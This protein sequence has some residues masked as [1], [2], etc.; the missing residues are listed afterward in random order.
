[1][2]YTGGLAVFQGPYQVWEDG[3][4][5]S[6]HAGTQLDAHVL[7]QSHLALGLSV[8]HHPWDQ[9]GRGP[10]S[11]A[12]PEAPEHCLEDRGP[13]RARQKGKLRPG[14]GGG[15]KGPLPRWRR[16]AY[17]GVSSGNRLPWHQRQSTSSGWERSLVTTLTSRRQCGNR[18]SGTNSEKHTHHSIK[19]YSIKNH[20]IAMLHIVTTHYAVKGPSISW[21]LGTRFFFF[22]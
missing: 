8:H 3:S 4:W 7:V 16:A 17:L 12:P 5:K 9:E 20:F 21:F 22:F 18:A 14:Q 15:R 1:M 19:Y 11:G 13:G 2:R 6:S 10:L